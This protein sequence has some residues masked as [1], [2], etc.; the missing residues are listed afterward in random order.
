MNNLDIKKGL[1]SIEEAN[2]LTYFQLLNFLQD[3]TDDEQEA[4]NKIDKLRIGCINQ[5]S[6]MTT[7]IV[8]SLLNT[9]F[10]PSEKKDSESKLI[11]K[12]HWS[13]EAWVTTDIFTAYIR[14]KTR[15]CF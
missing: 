14:K 6:K 8:S 13:H 7:R 3:K 12:Y 10:S 2:V 4:N 9:S 5:Q 15:C 11:I 1:R